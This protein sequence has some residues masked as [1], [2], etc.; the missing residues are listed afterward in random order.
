[1]FIKSAPTGSVTTDM[2]TDSKYSKEFIASLREHKETLRKTSIH[3]ILQ[4][5]GKDVSHVRAGSSL[6]YHSPFRVD[7]TPSFHVDEEN[8]RF[9]DP[10]DNDPNHIKPGNKQAGGDAIDLVMWLKGISYN[11]ALIYLYELNPFTVNLDVTFSKEPQKKSLATLQG[12][13]NHS[14]GAAGSDS[15]WGDVGKQFGVTSYHYYHGRK[16]PRGNVEIAE[17]ELSEGRLHVYKA[18][19]SLRRNPDRYMDLLAK[20]WIQVRNA[21]AVFAISTLDPK[22]ALTLRDGT[23]Y[24]PVSGGTGWAVQM[25]IDSNKPVYLF[26]Q[27]SGKWF[28]FSGADNNKFGWTELET[29]P[30]L[31]KNFAGIGTRD[32]NEAGRHAIND[33]YQATLRSLLQVSKHSASA[34]IGIDISKDEK[35]ALLLNDSPRPFIVGLMEFRTV[36]MFA[37]YSRARWENKE[38]LAGKILSAET[39]SELQGLKAGFSPEKEEEW[40]KVLPAVIEK[41]V[42]QSFLSNPSSPAA[43]ILLDTGSANLFV[44]G[45]DETVENM[46]L[47]SALMSIR[48]EMLKN[49]LDINGE[50]TGVNH[51]K[52]VSV[53]KGI[54]SPTLLDYETNQRKISKEVLDKYCSQIKYTVESQSVENPWKMHFSAIGF[55]NRSGEW[56]L[57]GAPYVGKDGTKKAGIKKSTGQ[58]ITAI[59][60]EGEFLD[61]EQGPQSDAVVVFE[62]FND[63]LSWL[64]W[65]GDTTPKNCDAVVLNS[66]SMLAR[67]MDFILGHKSVFAYFDADQAGV[68]ITGELQ[69]ACD[70]KGGI[71]FTDGS[72]FYKDFGCNDLNER[73]IKD[74]D[75]I[76]ASRKASKQE[77][78]PGTVKAVTRTSQGKHKR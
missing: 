4:A 11:E 26:D 3:Q 30:V 2:A 43:I 47:S 27:E 28:T 54:T 39:A 5:E 64:C 74:A 41:G 57:R 71:T 25:A 67:G 77:D 13:V 7:K 16:T 21:D 61:K 29:A 12:Y 9:S 1:M 32:I 58:D 14:G 36:E 44:S 70:G 37:M 35:Y 72:C 78:H 19:K 52:I 40:S 65:R 75:T 76:R 59:S 8:H 48:G 66:T 34:D 51:L 45:T 23:G 73:W 6:L 50:Y 68:R 55:P 18:N 24:V 17:N 60:P 20:N 15:A 46:A 56:T 22:G 38:E 63:F 33:T 69:K 10:G 62:G 31:T 49:I 42:R 53:S